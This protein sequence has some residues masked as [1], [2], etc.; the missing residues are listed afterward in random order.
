MSLYRLYL[1]C[2]LTG[3]IYVEQGMCE[4]HSG[5]WFVDSITRERKFFTEADIEA[6][7]TQLTAN[8]PLMAS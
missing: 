4:G 6:H 8:A 3:L 1:F 7:F 2:S 5:L